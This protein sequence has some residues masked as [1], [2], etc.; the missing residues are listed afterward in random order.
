M[1]PKPKSAE[2]KSIASWKGHCH[3]CCRNEGL[4]HNNA[5]MY[6]LQDLKSAE[7]L[8]PRV[9]AEGKAFNSIRLS[10]ME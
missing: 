2:A 6:A 8:L 7:P 4:Q 9:K 10:T 3:S 5:D 1:V